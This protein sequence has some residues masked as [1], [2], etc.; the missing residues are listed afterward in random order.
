MK[1]N[2]KGQFVKVPVK[3]RFWTKVDKNGPLHPTNPS[4]GKCWVWKGA[5]IK[6]AGCEYGLLRPSGRSGRLRAHRVS[7]IMK[8]GPIPKGK[9][10]LH[11]CDNPPCV[12]PSHLRPGTAA[13]NRADMVRRGR[14]LFGERNHMARLTENDVWD[15]LARYPIQKRT[16]PRPKNELRIIEQ[17]CKEYGITGD[18]LSRLARRDRWKHL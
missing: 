14:S 9:D 7:W 10:I 2:A 4:L 15:I 6:R 5:R 3:E 1:I 11:S 17:L 12:N 18:S 8:N 13:D 16:G